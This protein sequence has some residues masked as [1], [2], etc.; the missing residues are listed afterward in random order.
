MAKRKTIYSVYKEDASRR[1]LENTLPEFYPNFPKKKFD[2]IYA[3][4]PWD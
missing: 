3:D 1:K 2:I 4:P